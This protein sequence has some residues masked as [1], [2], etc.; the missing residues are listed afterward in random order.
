MCRRWRRWGCGSCIPQGGRQK[1]RP[2]NGR[3][4]TE[5]C[6]PGPGGLNRVGAEDG[7]A[8]GD[9]ILHA[10]GA[11]GDVEAGGVDAGAK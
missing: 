6:S 9:Q 11:G 5:A 3:R 7:G 4:R 2:W 8:E 10:V 1:C